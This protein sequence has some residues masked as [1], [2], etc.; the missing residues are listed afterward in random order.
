MC[1]YSTWNSV[2]IFSLA[3]SSLTVPPSL[4]PQVNLDHETKSITKKNMER[5]AASCFDLAQSK[6]YTLMEKDCYPR[7]LKSA[8]YVELSRQA[9]PWTWLWRPDMM[10]AGLHMRTLN[11][12]DVSKLMAVKVDLRLL[13]RN[14][15]SQPGNMS[16]TGEELWG[17]NWGS[18]VAML[19]QEYKK[20]WI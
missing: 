12:G 5:P 6:I 10:E 19:K 18:T 20:H 14:Y 3:F 7:F 11:P 4:A 13:I 1:F 9:M 2:R 16:G 17:V 8:L 15:R